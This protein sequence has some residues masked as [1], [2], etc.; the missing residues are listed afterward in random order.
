MTTTEQGK[1]LHV[2][3]AEPA[4]SS[5]ALFDVHASG[6]LRIGADGDQLELLPLQDERIPASTG[7]PMTSPALLDLVRT[8]ETEGDP[9]R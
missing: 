6:Q 1:N 2:E 8:T 7:E 4:R 3:R 5:G 9:N